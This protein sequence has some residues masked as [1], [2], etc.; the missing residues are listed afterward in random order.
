M[1]IE[2][3]PS[4]KVN[5]QLSLE[6]TL[7]GPKITEVE[8][9]FRKSF[10]QA[11]CECIGKYIS[12]RDEMLVLRESD[13]KSRRVCRSFYGRSL[14]LSYGEA[15][16]NCRQ[17]RDENGYGIPI[18]K[19]LGLPEK[20]KVVFSSYHSQLS[21]CAQST[22]RDAQTGLEN[23]VSLG[24]LHGEFQRQAG[25]MRKEEEAAL[26]YL[27]DVGYSPP[28]PVSHVARM[29][30]D[31]IY[32]RERT[33]PGRGKGQKQE[34]R[35]HL[36]V[37][38]T[39]C[40]FAAPEGDKTSGDSFWT[41]PPAVYASI[42]KA[43]DHIKN[44][45]TYLDA[46]TGLSR[47]RTVVHISDA[48]ANGK[49]HCKDY[50]ENSIWQLDW[51]HLGKHVRVLNKIDRKWKKE[52]WELIEVEQLDEAIASIESGLEKMNKYEP[53]NSSGS[54]NYGK[55][56]KN[57]WKKRIKE[58][59]GLATYLKNNREG[60]YAVKKLVGTIPGEHIPFGSGPMERLCGINVAHRMKGHGKAWK[61]E[62]GSNMVWMINR[63]FQKQPGNRLLEEARR[64]ALWWRKLQNS[65][66]PSSFEMRNLP[67]KSKTGRNPAK[68]GKMPILTKARRSTPYYTPLKNISK[69]QNIF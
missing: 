59:E 55:K 64:E 52:V 11:A 10:N 46:K 2:M 24:F 37:Q 47:C 68:P 49:R 32:I 60:I 7:Q 48:G 28:A 35:S 53:P 8:E 51:Y 67:S 13:K 62:S 23:P 65:P 27:N 58:V 43:A 29:M 14:K 22:F 21:R 31:A 26:E 9:G 42:E 25:R 5:I 20:K 66:L 12:K 3:Q 33:L 44:G 15:F 54:E 17:V 34:K 56:T 30:D 16:F 61:R 50:N 69:T 38:L 41:Y 40:D 39:R 19:E 57:W 36:Q 6:F 63:E 45:K 18:L 4:I 1:N